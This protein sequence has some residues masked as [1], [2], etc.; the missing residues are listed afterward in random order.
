MAS[1]QATIDLVVRGSNAVN[2]LI[3]NVGQ[4]Q[5]AVD[6]INS[7]TLNLAAPGLQKQANRLSATMEGASARANDLGRDRA[8]ILSD[9]R[10]AV[11]RLTQAQIRQQQA[12]EKTASAERELSKLASRDQLFSRQT[13]KLKGNLRES[14]AEAERLGDEM[15]AASAAAGVLESRLSAIRNAGRKS[16]A[17]AGGLIDVNTTLAASNAVNALANQ[18]NRYGD[19]LRRSARESKLVGTVLPGQIKSFNQFRNQIEQA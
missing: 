9:Q 17:A 18:Y 6:K 10:Q 19:S 2:A 11:E 13:D 15:N 1:T 8:Q 14:A 3:Q 7:K 12:I 16:I 5:S 4:L